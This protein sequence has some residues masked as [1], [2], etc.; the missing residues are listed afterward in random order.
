LYVSTLLWSELAHKENEEIK[1]G[2]RI[3]KE[4]IKKKKA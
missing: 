4:I 1:R 2:E 3:R